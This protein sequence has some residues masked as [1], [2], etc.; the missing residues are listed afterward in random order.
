MKKIEVFDTT[1]RDGAQNP[2]VS[3]SLQDKLRVINALDSFGVTYIEGGNPGS[4]P[5]DM[6]LFLQAKDM[7][8]NYAKLVAFCSTCRAESDAETD[9]QLAETVRAGTPTV[10]L[11]GKCWIL[12]VEKVIKTT[13]EEN[14]RIIVDSIKYLKSHEKEVFFDAEHFFDGYKDN[15]VFALD[16]LRAAKSAGADA[17]V[18]CDTNG[19]TMP[20]EIGK[21]TAEVVDKIGG[22]IGIHS[23]NDNGLSVASSIYAVKNGAVQVQGTVNGLGER[24]GNTN[25][26]TL[27]P[28]LQLKLGYQCV[29]EEQMKNITLLAR[30]IAELANTTFDEG[31]PFVGSYA[32]THKAGMHID[33]VTKISASFEH[34]TPETVGN[35]RNLLVSEVAGRSAVLSRMKQFGK[36]MTK[37]SPAVKKALEIV[38]EHESRG[39]QY[40]NAEGSLLLLFL[41]ALGMRRKF[42]EIRTFNIAIAEPNSCG[43]E[44]NPHGG[45]HPRGGERKQSAALIKVLVDGKEEIAAA[46]G[47]GP[48]NALDRALRKALTRFYPTLQD[49]KLIDFKVRVLDSASATAAKVRVLIESTDSARTWRT[50]GVSAD[51]IEASWNALLESVEYKLSRDFGLLNRLD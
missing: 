33:A 37:D 17:I 49:M 30:N 51:I 13:A 14:I 46:E 11:F 6:E 41:D 27:L 25:L 2:G 4:N 23:H 20:E 10:A 3:F 32:F 34:I 50:I 40:E 12:H 9:S 35:E 38:K 36:D 1:L 22:R 43:V 29:S 26:C 21:I 28:N 7:K 47:D 18:L 5:K 44:Y 48:V 19:G 45:E 42:F 31:A 39:Y 16:V 24:C 8:L 15:P